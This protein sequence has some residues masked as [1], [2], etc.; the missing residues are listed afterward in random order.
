MSR[1]NKIAAKARRARVHS[2][3]RVA[4]RLAD[5]LKR[6]RE[7]EMQQAIA[8]AEKELLS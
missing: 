1:Q 2:D 7:K 3:R 8:A 4:K 5:A 6:L